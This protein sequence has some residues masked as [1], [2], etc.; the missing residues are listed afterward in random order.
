MIGRT[1]K[2]YVVEEQLGKG[3]MGVV[4]RARDMKL[5]RAV[6]LKVLPPELMRNEERRRRFVQEARAAS[7]VNH[8]AIAPIY[9]I[10]EDG[11]LTF[12]AM[13]FVDGS[14]LRQLISRGE[15]D[16]PSAIEV[17]I[18][19]A[20]GLATAHEA[21]I[22]HRDIKSDNIM[23]TK[24]GHPKILDF[25]LAKLLD[26]NT[27]DDPDATRADTM[28]MTQA[29]MVL[30]TVAYMSPEQARGLPADPRSDMFS[31]GVVLYESATGKMPFSGASVLDT[32]HAIAFEQTTPITTLR[33]G[34]PYS[35]QRV[36]NRCMQKKP[37]DRYPT[38]RE[39]VAELKV[40]RRELESGVTG[41]QPLVDRA[42]AWARGLTTRG[43]I[44]IAIAGFAAGA[45]LV[46]VVFEK[47]RFN[48]GPVFAVMFFG[49]IFYRRFRNR[50][51]G[52]LAK[53]GKRAAK[54]T[55]VRL[56]TATGTNILVVVDNP[57]AKTYVKLNSILAQ[58]N[59]GLFHGEPFTL[60]VRENVSKE[61]RVSLLSSPGLQ[62]AAD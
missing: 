56:V 17:G 37:D 6:A 40:V 30:G 21:G 23:V 43:T 13:E 61:E 45:F 10:G 26:L 2:N 38:M 39:V 51:L 24:D 7:A 41:G 15:L 55:E 33:A 25:G 27:N 59:G 60:S 16:V 44:W 35:L 32:M 50:R 11:D 57:T 8:P 19:V 5:D 3:G 36:V 54:L 52:A 4:Y 46:G 34:L 28:A 22:V 12:I 1:L 9:E 53:F 47:G 31:F 42:R 29:G 48:M 58:T 62:Y 20:D 49:A 18:Q 14:T